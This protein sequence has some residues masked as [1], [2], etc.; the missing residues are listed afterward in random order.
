LTPSRFSLLLPK[1]YLAAA[2]QYIDA[3]EV[4]APFFFSV[5]IWGSISMVL[6]RPSRFG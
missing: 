6:L 4:R 2:L 5:R 1:V 3:V